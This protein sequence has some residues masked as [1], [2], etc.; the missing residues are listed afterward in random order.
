MHILVTYHWAEKLYS[1]DR[2]FR[3]LR[4]LSWSILFWPTLITLYGYMT[5]V[6]CLHLLCPFEL[7]ILDRDNFSFTNTGF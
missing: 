1:C 3:D 5:L 6:T 4:R 7:D 2:Q